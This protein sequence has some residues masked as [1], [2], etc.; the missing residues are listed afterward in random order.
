MH[1]NI[2]VEELPYIFHA[3]IILGELPVFNQVCT[4]SPTPLSALS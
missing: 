1:A 3:N 2:I 4:P